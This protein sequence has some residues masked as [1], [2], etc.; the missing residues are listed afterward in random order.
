MPIP[1]SQLQT[2]SNQGATVTAQTTHTSIR[3]AIS[4]YKNWPDDLNYEVYLQGSYAN[5]T[6]IFGNSDVDL[7]VELTSVFYSNLTAAEKASL[8]F[9][10]A[11]YNWTIFRTYVLN[12]LTQYYDSKL[13]DASGSKSIKVL[14]NNGRLKSDVVVAVTYD[15]YEDL[16][17]R[18]EG[19]TFWNFPNE[20]TQFINYPKPHRDNG[21]QKNSEG[22]QTV[23][24]NQQLEFLKM[25]E[26]KL[27][28]ITGI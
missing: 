27:F 20:T 24:I 11:S 13:I 5:F 28:K 1:N 2:W 19:I 6:N 7:V 23:G 12:A 15:Y 4:S 21:A 8:K 18:S 10:T 9:T 16:K 26:I 22:E 25:L 3:N 14:P 17:V